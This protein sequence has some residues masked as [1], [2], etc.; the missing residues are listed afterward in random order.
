LAI[1]DRHDK[2]YEVI[3]HAR[4]AAYLSKP[5]F[6]INY[7]DSCSVLADGGCAN[8]SSFPVCA[9][10]TWVANGAIA[11]NAAAITP[12]LP[13]G[14]QTND[15]LLLFV[16]T[17]NQAVTIPTPAGGTW[18][19]VPNTGVGTGTAGAAGSVRGTVFWSRYNGTQTAPTTSDSGAWQVGFI[20]AYRGAVTTGDPINASVGSAAAVG[21][22]TTYTHAGLTATKQNSLIIRAG[23]DGWANASTTR[24]SN[25]FVERFDNGNASFG[26]LGVADAPQDMAS[27]PAVTVTK[28]TAMTNIAQA[29]IALA[30]QEWT[31][32][33]YAAPATDPAPWYNAAYPE[34]ANALG[35]M[36]EE[37][38]GLD[39][40]HVTRTSTQWGSWG[41]GTNLGP[42]SSGG[43]AMAINM[44]LFGTTEE[45]VDYL[46]RWLGGVLN[47]VCA[48]CETDTI[49]IRRYCGS[50]ATPEAGIAEMRRVGITRGLGWESDITPWGNC[51]I[52]RAS[53]LLEAGDPC[54]YLPE[55]SGVVTTSTVIANLNTCFADVDVDVDAARGICRPSCSELE[56]SCRSTYTWTSTPMAA[57]AP[58][59]VFDNAASQHAYPFRAVVYADP[60]NVGASNPCG[61]EVLGQIYVRALPPWSTMIWDVAGREIRYSDHTTGGPVTSSAYIE[62]NDPPNRR[63]FAQG[64]AQAHLVVE[65]ATLCATD[66]G[67]NTFEAGGI[68][69]VN[70]TFPTV[71][72]TT[73]ERVSCA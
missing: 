35:F 49:L 45:S 27:V 3:N 19:Q 7:L 6:A 63:F 12:A 33:T 14:I 36:I 56:T 70:P 54:M 18:T 60:N 48:A 31:T 9:T 41:G 72:I 20:A 52:R 1:K 8:Y 15:I 30:P 57:I 38:T 28:N 66:L 44:M 17:S 46:F 47:S 39:D 43:R 65:P 69:F 73:Q 25:W 32:K 13:A 29:T 42:V 22:G 53:V 11:A 68:T 26:G 16:N 5:Q 2:V 50:T 59:I 34:S 51:Q 10:P 55:S 62:A 67:S 40:K 71:T 58:I 21:A 61:L 23:F 24:Y 4:L 64:C 37:W